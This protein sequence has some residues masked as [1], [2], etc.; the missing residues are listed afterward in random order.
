M[1]REYD[2]ISMSARLTVLYTAVF[3]FLFWNCQ[4]GDSTPITITTFCEA[5]GGMSWP[6][7]A[8]VYKVCHAVGTGTLCSCLC[9][10]IASFSLFHTQLSLFLFSMFVVLGGLHGQS[11]P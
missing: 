2:T 1:D 4:F 7:K 10:V 9:V 6:C 5:T 8:C 3:W 11:M